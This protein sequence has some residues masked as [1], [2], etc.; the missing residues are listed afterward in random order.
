MG[1]AVREHIRLH[2]EETVVV[3]RERITEVLRFLRDDPASDLHFLSDI[4][5]L[6]RLQLDPRPDERFAVVY[7]LSSLNHPERLRVRVHA[8]A[9]D[10]RVPSVTSLWAGAEW[11]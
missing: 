2:D 5:G 8:P 6:D 7:Q 10:P 11:L 4:A 1:P 9:S 3:D